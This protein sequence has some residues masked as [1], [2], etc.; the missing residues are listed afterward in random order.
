MKRHQIQ[1]S[2]GIHEKVIC[3][4]NF[5]SWSAAPSLNSVWEML[6]RI[7][8][9]T[10]L[11]RFCSKLKTSDHCSQIIW[12]HS[13]FNCRTKAAGFMTEV[14]HQT[15]LVSLIYPGCTLGCQLFNHMQQQQHAIKLSST[16]MDNSLE[17]L[18][19]F[20]PLLKGALA[21]SGCT[22]TAFSNSTWWSQ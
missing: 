22:R 14:S 4:A 15:Y 21:A 16:Q 18:H 1:G 6:G 2:K 5:H 10:Q 20:P 11:Q 3:S 12:S 13:D 17:L 8:Q 9:A 19:C 7:R